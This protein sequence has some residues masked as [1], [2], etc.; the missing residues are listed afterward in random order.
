MNLNIILSRILTLTLV[1]SIAIAFA[2]CKKFVDIKPSTNLIQTRDLFAT[3]AA[4]L[5]AVNGVYVQMRAS[6]PALGNGTLS[7]YAG[8]A[9]DEL[10][11]SSTSLEYDAFF[12]NSIS[13][14]STVVYSQLWSASYRI[15]YQANSIIENLEKNIQISKATRMQLLGEMKVVRSL[16]YFYLVNFFGD[17]PLVT[18]TDY[19]ENEHKGR[20]ATDSIYKQIIN[21]LEDAESF[22]SEEYPSDYKA[23][24]NKWTA[25]A[26]LAKVYLYKDNWAGA[27]DECSKIIN[28]GDYNLEDDLNLV[29]KNTSNETIWQIAPANEARNT[30]EGSVFIP[31]SS[32]ITPTIFATKALLNSFEDGDLRKSNWFGLNVSSGNEYY[33][34]FKYK[35]R[36]TS[37]VDEYDIV[38]RLAEI[39]LIRAE[40]RAHQNKITD[41]DADINVIRKRAGLPIYPATDQTTLL[42]AIMK[43]RQTE[44]FAEWGNRWLDL[45]RTGL[46]NSV[47]SAIK[48]DQWESTDSL[49]PI[50]LSEVQINTALVQ[51]PGY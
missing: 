48:V 30:V 27:E 15:I 34:P 45:K 17:V 40:A 20:T 32:T 39:Y 50:P 9:S 51:N 24:P 35:N 43:E 10:A 3:D 31:F 44:L 21:D 13:P 47:L 29:F 18:S 26:L 28:S 16:Y 23:R 49:F 38:F 37:P 8:L 36:A 33:Y 25:A 11:T 5:S 2:A 19:T 41:A 14:T 1:L 12:S 22:L 42:S 6:L 7:I 4:A 46:I